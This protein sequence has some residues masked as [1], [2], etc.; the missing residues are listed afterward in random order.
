MSTELMT[1][2]AEGGQMAWAGLSALYVIS[3]IVGGGLIL[4]SVA[5][6]GDDGADVEADADLDLD[7]DTDFDAGL[8]TEVDVD[9]DAADVE[10]EGLDGAHAGAGH[11]TEGFSIA[12]WL[13]LRF[14]IFFAATFGLIGTV[15]DGLS[16]Y[17]TPVV[18]AASVIGGLLL[19]QA[20]HQTV[21]YLKKSGGN[22]AIDASEYLRKAARVTV[23]IEPPHRGEVVTHVRGRSRYVPAVT[24]RCDDRFSHGE[25]VAIVAMKNGTAE[26]I[27]RR[28][29]VA[30]TENEPE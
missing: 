4:V 23:A 26:V 22:D 15:M 29:Y 13:S 28:E 2:L 10:I 16:G 5:S 17:S 12:E 18:L 19:G 7:L 11:L 1:L 24:K 8:D 3:L 27:S 6:G 25:H 30:L 21:R 14:F 20:V 9:V